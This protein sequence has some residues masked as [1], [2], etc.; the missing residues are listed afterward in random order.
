[1]EIVLCV[2]AF[3]FSNHEEWKII[4]FI[5]FAFI[6]FKQLNEAMQIDSTNERER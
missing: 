6:F 5:H 3:I 4:F 1:M 2:A